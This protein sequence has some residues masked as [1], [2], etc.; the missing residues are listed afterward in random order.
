MSR[1]TP[2]MTTDETDLG[3]PSRDLFLELLRKYKGIVENKK[4]DSVSAKSKQ[5]AWEK[6]AA[7]YNVR[8]R[9]L[10][11]KPSPLMDETNPDWTPSQHLGHGGGEG[12]SA[13]ATRY[14]RS[15]KGAARKAVAAKSTSTCSHNDAG[16]EDEVLNF[17]LTTE[18]G[19]SSLPPTF[20]N[21]SEN[22]RDAAVQ[23]DL[24]IQDVQALEQDNMRLTSELHATR[25]QQ[26]ILM[27]ESLRED[28]GK[29]F[30]YTGLANFAILFAT[31]KLVEAAVKHSPQ[32]GLEKF[33]EFVVFIMKLKWNFPLQDLAYRFNISC[34]TVSRIFDKWLHAAFWRLKTQIVW[35]SRHYIQKTMPQAFLDSFGD[36]VEVAVIID[37]FEIKIERPSSLL[38]RCETWSQYKSSNTGKYLIGISPQGL[39]VFISE[40]WGGRTSDKHMTERCGMLDNLR[41]GDVVLADRGFDIADTLGLYRASLHIPASPKGRNSSQH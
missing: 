20:T 37:C 8:C 16:D 29:V 40:G 19:S 33:T 26:V 35:P 25:K 7:E 22:N 10:E 5:Q 13:S 23:T 6:M 32:N 24:T 39:I 9:A 14:Y 1:R 41:E 36:K 27:E 30:S 28:P 34:S 38:P 2:Y 15:K 11:C 21:D 12:C 17:S 31:F 18:Q 3:I 4:T